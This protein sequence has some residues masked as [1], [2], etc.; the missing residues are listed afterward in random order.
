MAADWRGIMP[1]L[2]SPGLLSHS[3]RCAG[4]PCCQARL[5]AQ[6]QLAAGPQ[7]QALPSQ[8]S[9]SPTWLAQPGWMQDVAHPRLGINVVAFWVTFL[10]LIPSSGMAAL[11]STPGMPPMNC[12]VHLLPYVSVCVCLYVYMCMTSSVNV[13]FTI[14]VQQ[15][16]WKLDWIQKIR[17]SFLIKPWF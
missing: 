10:W 14:P 13:F 6:A 17:M 8:Q 9:C 3:L 11:H 7:P 1:T 12:L 5:L 2:W 15:L 16:D 4:H